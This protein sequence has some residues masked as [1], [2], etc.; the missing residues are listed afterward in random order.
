MSSKW[1]KAG[2]NFAPSYQVS[3]IPFV[4]S[5]LS[6]TEVPSDTGG[7]GSAFPIEV[8]FPYVTKNIKIRNTGGNALKVAFTFTGSFDPGQTYGTGDAKPIINGFNRNYF[9][10]PAA[11]AGKSDTQDFDVRC[12]AV[13]LLGDGGTTGFS[14][15]AGLTNI[16][17]ASFPTITGSYQGVTAFEGVG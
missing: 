4:T 9:L 15:Y 2:P 7:A 14:L 1:P 6:D 3:G 8:H 11:A 5:S 13:Y 17:T 16:T 12:K 10:I